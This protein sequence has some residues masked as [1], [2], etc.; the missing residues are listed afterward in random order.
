MSKCFY[1]CTEVLPDTSLSTDIL[2]GHSVRWFLRSLYDKGLLNPHDR[3]AKYIIRNCFAR[4][5]IAKKLFVVGVVLA[6]QVSY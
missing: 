5:H 3:I 6:R 1:D 2:Q 4:S